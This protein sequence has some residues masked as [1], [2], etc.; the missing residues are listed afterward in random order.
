MENSRARFSVTARFTRASLTPELGWR[1]VGAVGVIA[2]IG[3]T[4]ALLITELAYETE[5]GLLESAKVAVL[6]SS[7]VAAVL[8]TIALRAR[9]RHH[10]RVH[11]VDTADD[12]GDG[13]PDVYQDPPA[14]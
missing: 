10:A 11:A 8:A 13:V 3:F 14:R 12:D 9:S 7:V 2:G 6:T 4:V 5:P 1:D